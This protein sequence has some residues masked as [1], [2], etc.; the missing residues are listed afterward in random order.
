VTSTV[1]GLDGKSYRAKAMTPVQRNALVSRVHYLAHIKHMSVRGIVAELRD[2]NGV[3]VSVETA[4]KYL[5][6]YCCE[7]CKKD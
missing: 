2:V 7:V 1:I 4:Y 6:K 5:N 3:K